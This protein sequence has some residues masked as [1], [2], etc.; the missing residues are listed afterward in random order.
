MT[1]KD[2][3]DNLVDK[4]WEDRPEITHK[5]IFVQPFQYSGN[6][7]TLRLMSANYVTI[8]NL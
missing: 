4:V 2:I 1:W 6:R 5:K 3:D 7:I 8:I